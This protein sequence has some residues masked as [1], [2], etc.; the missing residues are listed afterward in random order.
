MG[1]GIGI[2]KRITTD[3]TRDSL[4]RDVQAPAG[5]GLEFL[6]KESR[7]DGRRF[8]LTWVVCRSA[9]VLAG[10]DRF[11]SGPFFEKRDSREGKGSNLGVV[12]S[13]Y[14]EGCES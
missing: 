5:G 6:G 14:V 4:E 7:V 10:M 3:W 12:P 11:A 2:R 13:V 8:F 9:V 1:I